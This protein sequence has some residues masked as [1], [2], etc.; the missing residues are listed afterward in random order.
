M[1][2]YE[3]SRYGLNG[4]S[5]GGRVLWMLNL[6]NALS[7]RA[8]PSRVPG[9]ATNS[10]GSSLAPQVACRACVSLL[11]FVHWRI[12]ARLGTKACHRVDEHGGGCGGAIDNVGMSSIL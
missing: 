11:S 10:K 5:R 2:G 12:L 3:E 4:P 7:I 6:V 9:S 8:I 1:N